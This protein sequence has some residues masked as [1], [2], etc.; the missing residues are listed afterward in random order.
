MVHALH[1]LVAIMNDA[2]RKGCEPETTQTVHSSPGLEDLWQ[3]HFSLLSGQE[4]TQ[5]GMFIANTVD[6]QQPAMPIAPMP[7]PHPGPG[8]PPPPA[9][10]GAAHWIKLSAQPNGS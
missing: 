7:A 4:Y 5:P 9:H 10:N 6:D 1:P 8:A 3:L 2:T